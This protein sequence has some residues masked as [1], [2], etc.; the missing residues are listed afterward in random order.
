MFIDR[1]TVE[2]HAGKGGNGVI[3]WRRE[4]FIPKG[5]PWGGN[6]GKGGSIILEANENV[7]SLEW[8]ANHRI[9]KAQ[10][11]A[12]GQGACKSGKN[13]QDLIL[14]VPCGTLVKDAETKEILYDLTTHKELI[15]LCL[16]GK[17]GKGNFVFR[18]ATN[19]AP[20]IC[21]PGTA[22]EFKEIEL[23][24]KM[25][26]DIGLVG[27]PNAGK[28]TLLNLLA[29]RDVKIGAYPFTTLHPNIGKI[30]YPDSK[31]LMIADIPGIIEGAHRDR[32]LG[33]E[34]LRHIE[35]TKVL[36]FV[37]DISGFEGRTGIDD[38]EILQKELKAYDPNLTKRPYFIALNKVDMEEADEKVA[39]FKR[40]FARYKSKI[41]PISAES[42]VGC[43]AL[44]EAVREAIRQEAPQEVAAE[45]IEP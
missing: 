26:A 20:N 30:R 32:G 7:A 6:G 31:P 25:I 16:G 27:F 45:E 5:G 19:R 38:Y 13:G 12:Q 18:S 34:F 29:K 24:L 9:I 2:C 36:I 10:N 40:R 15:T 28:S 35:R 17:G 22:G 4:K 23:E 39:E 3:A 44:K 11:G 21:T 41:F 8:Y 42:G 43:D 33:L 14:K 37:I 1:V